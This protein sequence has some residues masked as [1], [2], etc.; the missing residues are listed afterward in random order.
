[1]ASESIRFDM[2]SLLRLQLLRYLDESRKVMVDMTSELA[3][4][5]DGW[6]D[7]DMVP[8]TISL[9]FEVTAAFVE[10]TTEFQDRIRNL[11]DSLDRQHTDHMLVGGQI[12][13]DMAREGAEFEELF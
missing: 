9:D 5:S 8:D 2:P 7:D 3:S 12:D 13:R 11:L 10:A 4:D 1:M 6:E